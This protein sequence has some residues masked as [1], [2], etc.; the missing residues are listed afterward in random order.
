MCIYDKHYA[1][2]VL[3]K[4]ID[5]N[6]PKILL[7]SALID[8]CNDHELEAKICK[9]MTPYFKLEKTK[10]RTVKKRVNK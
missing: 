3:N 10:K 6:Q 8:N 7:L 4:F 2:D 5:E 1:K 9:H